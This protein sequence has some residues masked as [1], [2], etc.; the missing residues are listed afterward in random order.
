MVYIPDFPETEPGNLAV[1][2]TAPDE[3]GN[4]LSA[5]AEWIRDQWGAWLALEPRILDLQHRAAVAIQQGANPT[6]GREIIQDLGSLSQLHGKVTDKVVS[7]SGYLGLNLGGLGAVWVPFAIAATF[8]SI[9]AVMLWLMRRLDLQQRLVEGLEQGTLTAADLAAL[10]DSPPGSDVLGTA[11]DM[12]KLILWGIMAYVALLAL[13][14]ARSFRENPDLLVFRPN[15]DD[16]EG[17]RIGVETYALAYQHADNREPYV[18][19][20][21]PDVEVWGEPDG[22][23]SLHSRSGKRLWRDFD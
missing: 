9:A 14:E 3:S 8:A 13:R 7:L 10:A 23:V 17:E 12:G 19:N 5:A 16:G 18:H 6:L 15:P 11:V 21:G 2:T 20:F 22:S 4:V 1:T